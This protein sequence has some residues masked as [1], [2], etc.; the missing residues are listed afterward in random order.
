MPRFKPKGMLERTAGADLW[1][2]TLSQ[3]PTVFGRLLYLASLRDVNSGNYRHYGLSSS[4]GREE[5]GKALRESHEE[6]FAEWLRLS[7]A[8]QSEDLRAYLMTQ[9]DPQGVVIDHWLRSRI[10]R[11]QIPGAARESERE[12]FCHDLK[13]LLETVK[14]GLGG[15]GTRPDSSRLS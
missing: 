13:A 2:H 8:E 14:N 5:S 11:T 3:I 7:M 6:V 9:E 10:Y 1:K 4:F 15:G 12:H